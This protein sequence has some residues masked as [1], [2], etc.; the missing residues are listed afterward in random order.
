MKQV[1]K[2]YLRSIF[3]TIDLRKKSGYEGTYIMSKE[4][5]EYNS[6]HENFPFY[7]SHFRTQI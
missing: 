6:K 1:I 5:K 7:N 2:V 4:P 3:S